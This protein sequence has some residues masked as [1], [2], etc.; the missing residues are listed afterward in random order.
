[1]ARYQPLNRSLFYKHMSLFLLFSAVMLSALY[2]ANY[3]QDALSLLTDRKVPAQQQLQQLRLEVQVLQQQTSAR[4]LDTNRTTLPTGDALLAS[5]E[6]L[7]ASRQYVPEDLAPQLGQILDQLLPRARRQHLQLVNLSRELQS[8]EGAQKDTLQ[9]IWLEK[10]QPSWQELDTELA[11]LHTQLGGHILALRALAATGNERLNWLLI[12]SIFFIGVVLIL[13]GIRHIR[14]VISPIHKIQGFAETLALGEVP[15][16]ELPETSNE[17]G[18]VAESLNTT[19]DNMRRTLDAL[20]AVG[21][22]RYLF[23][24]ELLD[25][26]HELGQA[27]LAMRTQL[28]GE[29]HRME[30][31]EYTLE[32]LSL[33]N[34]VLREHTTLQ[35]LAQE[36]INRM[37]Q[38]FGANM[39][40]F[41]L[42]DNQVPEEPMLRMVASY[43]YSGHTEEARSFRMGEGLVGQAAAELE[44]LY[45]TDI[46]ANYTISTGMGETSP[47]CIL[48]Q[49]LV[50]GNN[51]FGVMEL[52]SLRA[53]RAEEKDLLRKISENI[54][55]VVSNVKNNERTL[56]L[57]D[58]S[59]R[60]SHELEQKSRMLER[61]SDTMRRTQAQLESANR[62][63]EAQMQQL[64]NTAQELQQSE[65]KTQTLLENAS[66]IISINEKDGRIRYLSP[67]VRRILGYQP[68]E[69]TYYT[70]FVHLEDQARFRDFVQQLLLHPEEAQTLSYQYQKRNGDWVWLESTGRNL[71]SDAHINGLLINTRDITERIQAEQNIKRR[72]Q[73]QSLTE[74]SP[75]LIMRYDKAGTFLYIN[76]IIEKY[77]GQ[78]PGFYIEKS[79]KDVGYSSEEENFWKNLI[80]EAGR[81]GR[82]V[83]TE[84]QMPTILGDRTMRMDVIPERGAGDDIDSI[85]VVSHDITE[86]RQA[87]LRILQQKEKL[88]AV[89]TEMMLQKA[90]LET[91]NQDITESIQYA[92][93]I[94]EAILPPREVFYNIFQQHCVVFQPRDIVSGDFYYYTQQG[95]DH[96]LA[97]VDCTGHGVPGAFM[98][99][100]GYNSLNQ[101]INTLGI[102]ET[103]DILSVLNTTIHN[104]LQQEGGSNRDGMDLSLLRINTHKRIIQ[105][106]GAMRPVLWWHQ[107]ELH[108]V[109][110][111]RFSIGG[112]SISGETPVFE[113]KTLRIE[114]GDTIY[115][116]SDGVTDQFGGPE[117]R[118]F[119]MRRLRDL[120]IRNMH[121][122]MADQEQ[123]LERTL[124]EWKGT[125]QQTDDILIVGIRF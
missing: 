118:K 77:S 111:S 99:L 108:E 38:K 94:Q 96:Y 85:L 30:R 25:S 35:K 89:N 95:E 71:I 40:A 49:P 107:Y 31:Y 91:K 29:K 65:Y 53:F 32:G 63:L 116:F 16:I 120:L 70:Q 114:P 12:L 13:Y 103:S 62:Q 61:G 20:H 97:V 84:Y 68:H 10:V 80:Y 19:A 4:L 125:Q 122:S 57:L 33:F 67:S 69:L 82:K 117:G 74:N 58:N 8:K 56:E 113:E 123:L 7:Y 64:Q 81:S 24:D 42:L 50:S 22:G 59:H 39:G 43:A 27:I 44:T 92:Q 75:D 110:G 102:S 6:A 17:L 14:L 48:I 2:L 105:F 88:E 28:I 36:L 87:E 1:M 52:A 78:Q 55:A 90:E 45:L 119:S 66:E 23:Y 98:S 109:R 115:L 93:R 100:I 83:T 41:F 79:I 11:N 47:A 37:V 104:T 18:I 34:D 86:I 72:L 73:F 3:N 26:P 15:D 46:P 54:A 106:S 101:T 121:K 21:Q 9:G 112:D 60:L 76:P 5:Q 51:V 124:R